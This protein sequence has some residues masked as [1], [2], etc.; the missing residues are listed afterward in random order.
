MD[1][2]E[3]DLLIAQQRDQI[4]E[5]MARN[6]EM[7]HYIAQHTRLDKA[8]REIQDATQQAGAVIVSIEYHFALERLANAV[9]ASAGMGMAGS[10][11][12]A[13]LTEIEKYKG[14]RP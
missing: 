3:M 5:L 6:T 13:E 4:S 2:Y 9:L 12:A 14:R 10:K 1:Q 7:R 8:V 11:F